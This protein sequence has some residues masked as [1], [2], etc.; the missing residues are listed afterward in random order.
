[1]RLDPENPDWIQND[2]D[3]DPDPP[4]NSINCRYMYKKFVW[5]YYIYIKNRFLFLNFDTNFSHLV[6]K[7]LKQNIEIQKNAFQKSIFFIY[8]YY[9]S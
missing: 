2:M 3:M 1:M 6:K 4:K 7:N 8:I 5:Q 9:A